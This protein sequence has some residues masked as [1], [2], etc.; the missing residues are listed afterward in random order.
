MT[1][2]QVIRLAL[3]RC[4]ARAGST[5]LN[6]EALLELQLIQ[7][8]LEEEPELPWFL[9][10]ESSTATTQVGEPR[11]PVPSDF[12]LELE[13]SDL[14]AQNSDGDWKCLIKIE[15]DRLREAY[16][17]ADNGFPKHYALRGK[18]FY[19][20]PTPSGAYSIRMSYFKTDTTPALGVTNQWTTYAADWL[21][22]ELGFVLAGQYLSDYDKRGTFERDIV[23]ARARVMNKDVARD[24][25]NQIAEMRG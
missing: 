22:A 6:T 5:Q 1:V 7:E 21:V 4:G 24:E 9:L 10:S 17:N 16:Q 14:W 23:R 15:Y 13:Q 18:Y 12:L 20:G 11:V 25:T 3:N 2:D 19:L 8:R